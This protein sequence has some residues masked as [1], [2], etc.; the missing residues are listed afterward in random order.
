MSLPASDN[1]QA[2]LV[3]A[4]A[5]L[6]VVDHQRNPAPTKSTAQAHRDAP[7]VRP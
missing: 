7:Q 3:A 1:R 2:T 4:L 5:A 6:L